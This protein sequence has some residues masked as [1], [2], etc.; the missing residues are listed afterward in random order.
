[1]SLDELPDRAVGGVAV[2]LEACKNLLSHAPMP[3]LVSP[4]GRLRRRNLNAGLKINH[5]SNGNV[6]TQNAGVEIPLTCSVGSS[7]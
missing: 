2:V 1:M 5:Y 7:F 3:A 4:V 6:F